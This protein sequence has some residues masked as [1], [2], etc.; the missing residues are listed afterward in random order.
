MGIIKTTQ[1]NDT[2]H[3]R[4]PHGLVYLDGQEVGETLQCCHCGRHFVVRRG[5]GR[6]RGWCA[7][8]GKPTCGRP[9][10]VPC[11]PLEKRMLQMER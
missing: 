11:V 4:N 7:I 8:E 3:V 10:C 6:I 5:S 1:F 2:V 9:E